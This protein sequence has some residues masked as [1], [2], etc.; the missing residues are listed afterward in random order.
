M[1]TSWLHLQERLR[2]PGEARARRVLAELVYTRRWMKQSTRRKSDL[3]MT[4]QRWRLVPEEGTCWSRESREW[5][6]LDGDSGE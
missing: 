3:D 5:G 2:R 6:N 1:R 4:F